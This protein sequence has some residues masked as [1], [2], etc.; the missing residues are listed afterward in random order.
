MKP[1][2]VSPLDAHLGYWMRFVSNRVSAQFQLAVEEAG[3]S[4]AE[5]VA[6]RTLLDGGQV[7]HGTL[8]EALGMTK[9][10]VSKVIA[11]LEDKGL[12]TRQSADGDA[13]LLVLALTPAGRALVPRLAAI[14][15]DNDRQFFGHLPPQQRE[16]LMGLLQEIVFL[17]QLNEVPV[18]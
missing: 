14:A 16:Q 9:G 10:A 17:H 3:V 7:T 1:S 18:R 6:L 11:R 15:D 2:P 13:R 8:T 4:V 5:W 12:V